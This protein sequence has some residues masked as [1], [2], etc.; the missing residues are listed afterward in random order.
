MQLCV[1]FNYLKESLWEKEGMQF[2]KQEKNKP[3][4]PIHPM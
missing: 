1:T 2:V 4:L 3:S